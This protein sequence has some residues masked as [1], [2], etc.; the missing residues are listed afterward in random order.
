M[1]IANLCEWHTVCKRESLCETEVCAQWQSSWERLHKKA[2]LSLRSHRLAWDVVLVGEKLRR[3]VDE[4]V[5]VRNLL[6]SDGDC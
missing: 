4:G 6:A 3:G 2:C 5:A 1:Q